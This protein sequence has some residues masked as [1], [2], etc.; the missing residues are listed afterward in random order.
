MRSWI[1]TLLI[2]VGLFLGWAVLSIA[3]YEYVPDNVLTRD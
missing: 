3:T 1:R 2:I